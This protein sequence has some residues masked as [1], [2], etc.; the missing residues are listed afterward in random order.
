MNTFKSHLVNTGGIILAF[1][2]DT[3]IDICLTAVTLE[4]PRTI[5]AERSEYNPINTDMTLCL[6]QALRKKSSK[7]NKKLFK[8]IN[9]FLPES[10][11]VIEYLAGTIIFTGVTKTSI[12]FKFTVV[13]MIAGWAFTTILLKPDQ[14]TSAPMLA[15]ISITHITLGQ[16]IGV[17]FF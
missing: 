5:A 16:N 11:V 6:I 8:P 9:L 7:S 17:R 2:V 1:M 3:V 10:T 4:S 14:V 15:W 12:Y 13:T